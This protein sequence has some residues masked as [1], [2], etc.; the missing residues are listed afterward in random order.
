MK[1]TAAIA[2]TLAIP[3][4]DPLANMPEEE[5]RTR[6]VVILRLRTDNGLEGIG[7]TFYG[8]KMTGSLRAAV[9]E[10]GALT[11][12]EDRTGRHFHAGAVGDRHRFVG[13]HM[14]I[15]RST[16]L[17]TARRLSRQSADLCIGFVAARPDR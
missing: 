8:G 2:T 7:L 6:P 14:K 3:E 17:E 1:I 5:G 16:A 11:I 10:L 4:D 15:P 12:G 13:H 9:E